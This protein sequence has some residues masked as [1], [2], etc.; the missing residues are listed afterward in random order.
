MLNCAHCGTGLS[1]RGESVS[2]S[3]AY[4][5]CYRCGELTTWMSAEDPAAHSPLVIQQPR[6]KPSEMAAATPPEVALPTEL[7]A[8]APVIIPAKSVRLPKPT[9]A[10]PLKTRPKRGHLFA[11]LERVPFGLF[12]AVA[13]Y[14]A[15]HL[16]VLK[17]PEP[18]HVD[19]VLVSS[20]APVPTALNPK[21]V[22]L[23][24]AQVE[25]Q[26]KSAT[27]R[28][29]PGMNYRK[30]SSAALLT[31]LVVRSSNQDWLEVQVAG[32]GHTAW[33]RGD[34]VKKVATP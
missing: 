27:L 24:V 9:V 14:F 10:A 5:K 3:W 20:A 19:S 11:V 33:I 16:D 22:V 30:I 32:L 12:V 17:S 21:A 8:A 34:L 4:V 23:P 28:S 7:K 2:R 29:G 6:I 15:I 31:K 13:A 25:V 18:E 1:I 26:A